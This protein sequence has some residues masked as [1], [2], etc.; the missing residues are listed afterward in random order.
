MLPNEV[1]TII[2]DVMP[3][4][5]AARK[6]KPAVEFT[7][8]V[9]FAWF[10]PLDVETYPEVVNEP[11][12]ICTKK[13]DVPLKLTPRNIIVMRFTQDGMPVKSTPTT[14]MVPLTVPVDAGL[15]V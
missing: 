3:A 12:P 1:K 11:E 4:A 8:P 2:P 13:L 9:A 14:V 10:V 15:I 7:P 6:Q 5:L